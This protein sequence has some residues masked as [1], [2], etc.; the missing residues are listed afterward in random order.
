MA[1]VRAIR[2]E[3]PPNT[4]KIKDGKVM[5]YSQ[6]TLWN[7]IPWNTIVIERREDGF[8]CSVGDPGHGGSTVHGDLDE[9]AKQFH[10][11]IGRKFK[12]LFM[13]DE[14]SGAELKALGCL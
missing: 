8:S 10:P 1:A 3:L 11:T 12:Q 5:K 6:W 2:E 14:P 7:G 4:I 13:L 9:V